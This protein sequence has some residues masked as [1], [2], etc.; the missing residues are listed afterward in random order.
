MKYVS[1]VEEGA[2]DLAWLEKLLAREEQNP[3]LDPQAWSQMEER[4]GADFA[5]AVLY[6]LTRK[7][8]EPRQA[9]RYWRG[10]VNH[11]RALRETLGRDLGLRAALCDYF[12][13]IEPAVKSPLILEE[14]L[15]AQKEQT[16]LCDELTGLFNR[17]FFNSVLAKQI[18][19]SQRFG[20]VFSLLLVDV[21][22]FK[23]Y[24]DRHGH[25]A[26][27]QAL[28]EIAGLLQACARN[29]DYVVRFGGEEFAVI[30]PLADKGQALGVA[31]RH[32][33]AVMAHHFPG[34]EIMPQGRLTISL[35]VATFPDD[36]GDALDLIQRADQALYQAKRQGRNQV[37]AAHPERRRHPRVPF[38]VPVR[39]RYLDARQ[40]FQQGQALD[41]SHGGLGLQSLRAV[42]ARR[43]LELVIEDPKQKLDISVQGSV[44]RV[45]LAPGK[46]QAY[47]L[48]V[49][50]QGA[51]RRHTA[52]QAL[53][54]S[55][56][57]TIQ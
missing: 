19:A 27:D 8:F 53:V 11:R 56:L 17:R 20:Q 55:R 24:N 37:R 25:L 14:E 45:S 31:Q 46:T 51:P 29:I 42:D 7:T 35:G 3:I 40:G 15:F 23:L 2:P 12:V 26:G 57:R 41:I 4:H 33:E 38:K 6:I 18:A 28:V 22:W 10:I 16:A 1:L 5:R 36:A 13:N 21:D 43:P 54:E 39:Y 44:V 48:G 34:Q 9:Q 47:N 50:L 52:F 32:R 30:L 49:S